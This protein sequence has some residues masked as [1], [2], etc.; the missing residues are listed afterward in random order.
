MKVGE[1]LQELSV[2]TVQFF[3]KPK[4]TLKKIVYYLEKKKCTAKSHFN[5]PTF[6]EL[7]EKQCML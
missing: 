2:L 5:S 1:Y 6:V 3:Y 4:T 7:K